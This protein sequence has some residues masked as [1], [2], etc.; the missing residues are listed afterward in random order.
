MNMTYL[1]ALHVIF[2]ITWFSGLFYLG[3]LF[4]Y[5]REAADKPQPESTILH[6]QFNLMIKRLLMGVIWPSSILTLVIGIWLLLT[7]PIKPLPVWLHIKTTLVLLLFIFQHVLHRIYKQQRQLVFKYTSNQLN[8]INQVPALFLACIVSLAVVKEPI[9]LAYGLM[10]F[11][12]F[13]GVI[14]IY[15]IIRKT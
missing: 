12:L 3:R 6:Q 7:Y 2:V 1:T 4:L 13:V 9:S 5:N 14:R 15:K 11:V 10:G 8:I